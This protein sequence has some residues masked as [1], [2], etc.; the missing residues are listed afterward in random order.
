[1][2]EK[3]N[4]II[5]DIEQRMDSGVLH[6]LNVTR[7]HMLIGDEVVKQSLL[8]P[9][10]D[11][12]IEVIEKSMHKYFRM[13]S[14][15]DTTN[16]SQSAKNMSDHEPADLTKIDR[17]PSKQNP[18][19]FKLNIR[20]D[21]NHQVIINQASVVFSPQPVRK[22]F[23]STILESL[24]ELLGEE[25]AAKTV[26]SCIEES[27]F[28]KTIQL[29]SDVYHEIPKDTTVEE[30]IRLGLVIYRLFGLGDFRLDSE[31]ESWKISLK[32]AN[33][34]LPDLDSYSLG[35]VRGIFVAVDIDLYNKLEFLLSKRGDIVTITSKYL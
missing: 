6:D 18:V 25:A 33:R 5:K 17:T 12:I 22:I 26:L 21:D 23:V 4:S 13:E 29:L 15:E 32:Y 28:I 16:A 35:Y 11:S 14:E 27:V 30:K 20:K 8:L 10:D 19:N 2:G 1:M 7:L 34:D 31:S 9:D 24:G 3:L